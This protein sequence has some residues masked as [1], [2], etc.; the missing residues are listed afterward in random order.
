M[1]RPKAARGSGLL[2]TSRGCWRV[3]LHSAGHIGEDHRPFSS[4]LWPVS[5]R[6]SPEA[7]TYWN[8]RWPAPATTGMPG[9]AC[10]PRA[11]CRR[12]ARPA[13]TAP[14]RRP[15]P[16]SRWRPG[17]PRSPTRRRRSTRP[18]A[19]WSRTASGTARPASRSPPT[20]SFVPAPAQAESW[21]A[22]PPGASHPSPPQAR[23]LYHFG[24]YPAQSPSEKQKAKSSSRT[25]RAL[26]PHRQLSS[27]AGQPRHI[28]NSLSNTVTDK[29]A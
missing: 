16:R 6:A 4:L 2:I 9:T 27:P 22:H 26:R 13:T 28:R 14:P 15:C 12:A 8:S 25:V 18:P 29:L 21:S 5:L 1:N 11:S 7:S 17:S 20:R 23:R 10:R 19:A 3:Q 24:L